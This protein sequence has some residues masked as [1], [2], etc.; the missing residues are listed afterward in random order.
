M[1]GIIKEYGGG[2]FNILFFICF[3]PNNISIGIF[4][5]IKVLGEIIYLFDWI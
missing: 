5:Y 1:F 3:F 2:P 4:S